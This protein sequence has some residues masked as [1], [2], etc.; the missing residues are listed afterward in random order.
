MCGQG[1][2]LNQA[3]AMD[4]PAGKVEV[5]EEHSLLGVPEDTEVP[6]DASAIAVQ[7]A[8]TIG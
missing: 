4:G 8:S 3:A 5:V 2:L 6:T 7:S 1:R